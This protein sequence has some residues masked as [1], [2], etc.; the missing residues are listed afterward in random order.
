MA[1]RALVDRAFVADPVADEAPVRATADSSAANTVAPAAPEADIDVAI[2]MGADVEERTVPVWPFRVA[3][4]VGAFAQSVHPISHGEWELAVLLAAGAVYTLA[5]LNLSVPFRNDERL[6]LSLL[7]EQLFVVL[8]VVITGNWGSPL[9]LMFVPI[10]MFAGFTGGRRFSLYVSGA[11]VLAVSAQQAAFDG[12]GSALRAGALWGAVLGLIAI[13]SGLAHL[14]YLDA[15]RQQQV[16]L[17]RVSQVAEANSLLFSLQRVAQSLPTSLDLDEVLDSTIARLRT[18]LRHDSIAVYVI[19]NDQADLVRS[20]GSIRGDGFALDSLPM[21]LRAAV[22]S[23]RPVRINDMALG[24]GISPIARSGLYVALRARGALVGL[25][26]VEFNSSGGYREHQSEVV[27]GLSEP[28]GIAIDNARMFR[29]I[30]T[31]AADEERSRIARD[32]HDHIGSSLALIGF[33]IDRAISLTD[34]EDEVAPALRELRGHVS[35]AVKD[36]RNTLFDLRTEVQRNR[37]LASTA[38]GFLDQVAQRSGLQTESRFSIGDRLPLGV[39]REVWQI[40]REAIVNAERHAGGSKI[41]VIADETPFTVIISVLDNGVGIDATSPRP[42]SYGLIG[43]TERAGRLGAT[44]AAVPRPG[45][46]TEVRLTVPRHAEDP[47]LDPGVDPFDRT[48][49]EGTPQP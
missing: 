7:V 35:T 9:A 36:V 48:V 20:I 29:G 39:E 6:R 11:A 23:P 25:V 8:A 41:E 16:A 18:M 47:D 15:E 14:A 33:E 17:D 37:D 45:G 10:S 12:V 34:P 19:D 1:D 27:H 5:S 13:A 31:L 44:V 28:F 49:T 22:D 2:D 3:A 38:A 42:D 21:G 24:R 30:R 32:L 26:A 4:L 46:G 43:M 40:V